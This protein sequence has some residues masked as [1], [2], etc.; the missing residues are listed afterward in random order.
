MARIKVGILGATGMVGQWFGQL[1]HDHPWFEVTALAA[2]ANSAGRPYEEACRWIVSAEVPSSMQGMEVR[3][4]IPDL[5]CQVVFSAL[6]GGV[7]GPVEEA[8]AAAGY[9][10]FSNARDHRMDP[11]VPLL[12]PEVNPRH[13]QII[14]RQRRERGWKGYIVTNPN[15][16]TI[17]MVLALKP[18]Q[19]RFGLKRVAVVTLQALSGAGYPGVPSLEIV[20]NVVPYIE[21]EEKKL[22]TEPLKILGQLGDG[23]FQ[24]AEIAISAQCNRVSTLDGH[25]E[26]ISVELAEE[27]ELGEVEGAL[28]GFRALPQ[29]L[30]LPTAP[31]WPI[32]VRQEKDR[33]QP[34]YDRDA[35]GGMAVTVGRIR[36]CSILD[37]KFLVLG[38]NV[39]RGAAGASI[40]NAELLKAQGYLDV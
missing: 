31:R 23:E 3:E 28:R 11:D 4:C 5:P 19:D 39:V 15:C 25:L 17:Q 32:V 9:F 13:I 2:S 40:L 37:Y 12:V 26:C 14:E 35:E 38:H 8:F 22:E 21:G 16:C 30:N 7:A 20:D 36:R 29:E 1:L 33:P 18:L 10:V 34:R 6:P 24:K 27:A